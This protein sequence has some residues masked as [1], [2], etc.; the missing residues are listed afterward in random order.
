MFDFADIDCWWYN[1]VSE[2]WELSTYEYWNGSDTV[3]I[4]FEHPQYNYNQ[5][6]HTSYENCEN[7]GKAVWWMMAKL[8]GWEDGIRLNLKVLLEGPFNGTV[9]NTYIAAGGDLPLAQPYNIAP[10]NYAGAESVTAIPN[11]DVVDWVLIELRDTT[12]A[13]LAIGETMISR[14]A[15]FLLNDGSVVGL[16]GSNMP[17]HVATI[18]NNLFVVIWH[19]NHLGIMSANPVTESGGVYS[20]DF[21]TGS[22]QAYGA[23]P[24]QKEIAPGIWGMFGGDGDAD[25]QVNSNDKTNVWVI[26]V[27]TRGYKSGDMNMDGTVN[28]PDKNDVWIGNVG[29][30][31]QVPD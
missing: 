10:W 24:G 6:G 26:Q 29:S 23:A 20:Y 14:Q 13:S 15:A 9:M 3:T 7:K 19:R 17:R 8:T 4:P 22:G 16:D 31:S 28:N 18:A 2:E 27:G 12:D 25:G 11:A 21:T 5:A 1:P 30:N